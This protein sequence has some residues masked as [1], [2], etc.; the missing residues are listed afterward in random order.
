MNAKPSTLQIVSIGFLI[1]GNLI[2]AG[3]LALPINTGLSGFIP[4]LLGL[5]ITSAA[6]YYSAIILS[7]EAVNRQESTFNYPSLYQTYL[8]NAGKWV[9]VLANLIIL[10]GLLTAYLTGITSIIDNLFHLPVKPVWVMLGFFTAT[11]LISLASIDKITKYI[12]VLVL[13]KCAVFVFIAGMAG[14][15]VEA[16][17]LS[18]LNWPLFICGIPIL[19][20]A[21]HFHNII[22]AI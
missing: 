2:G 17:N 12:A 11:A 18:H 19:I 14:S 10:Y 16:K 6:M 9:A 13:V 4:S 7:T 21:F 15:H 1:V 8:G 20:T 22:P 5:F 3:I